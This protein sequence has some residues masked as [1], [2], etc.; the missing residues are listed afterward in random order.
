MVKCSW[1]NVRVVT[2]K[3]GRLIYGYV[4]KKY[5]RTHP[6]PE[7]TMRISP[8]QREK[9][10]HTKLRQ[11]GYS[12]SMLHK[13]SGRS[14]SWFDRLFKIAK[15]RHSIRRI[16]MRKYPKGQRYTYCIKRW[17]NLCKYWPLWEKWICGQGEKPP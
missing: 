8:L 13:I 10:A 3:A 16:D 12:I 2:N 4:R 6:Y 17:I 15:E 14:T 7:H 5:T 11:L 9:A 1:G